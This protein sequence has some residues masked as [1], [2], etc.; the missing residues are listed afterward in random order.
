MSI[1]P[2]PQRIVLIK[3]GRF[4][5]AEVMLGRSTHLVGPNNIGKTSLI[6]TVQFLYVA[7]FSEMRFSRSWDESQ[8]YYFRED[9]S[10]I[11]FETATSDGR[12][13]TLGL[14]GRGQM[15]GFQIDRFAFEGPYQRE[16]FLTEAETVRSFAEVKARLAGER[17]FKLLEPADI[18]LAVVG[19][20]SASP[21]LNMGI[22]PLKRSDRYGDFV[23]L[24]KNLLRLS[25]LSQQDIKDTLLNVYRHDIQTTEIDLYG[26]YA[27]LLTKLAAERAKLQNLQEVA[28]RSLG[29]KAARSKRDRA[30]KDLPAMYTVLVA[31]KARAQTL[32]QESLAKQEKNSRRLKVEE[33]KDAARA[34]ELERENTKIVGD[35]TRVSDW[36]DKMGAEKK[37]LMEYLPAIADQEIVRLKREVDALI[38]K[39][40]TLGDLAALTKS[41]ESV[42]AE[43]SRK[44]VQRDKHALL[45]GTK[46]SHRMDA[47]ALS[48]LG[49][50]FNPEILRLPVEP[51]GIQLT[52]EDS[53]VETLENFHSSISGDSFAGAGVA[54]PLERLRSGGTLPVVDI[55]SLNDELASLENQAQLLADNLDAARNRQLIEDDRRAKKT[56][57]DIAEAMQVRY[58]QWKQDMSSLSGKKA[59]LRSLEAAK[60]ANLAARTTIKDAGEKRVATRYALANELSE[61]KN[62]QKQIDSI[63]PT[64]VDPTWPLGLEDPSWYHM[65]IAELYDTYSHTYSTLTDAD[66]EV[67]RLLNDAEVTYRDGFSGS[68]QDERIDSLLE[69]VDSLEQNTR[70]FRDQLGFVIQGMRASFNNMFKAYSELDDCVKEFSRSIG[71][72]SISNLSQMTLQLYENTEVTKHYRNIRQSD[73][74]DDPERTEEAIKA[75]S[76]TIENNRV[77]RLSDWFG[78]RFVITDASGETKRYDDLTVMESNGTTMAIKILVNIV[79]IRAMMR[80]NKPFMI[81]FYIDEATQIDESNLREIVTVANEMGFCPVLASTVPTSVAENIDSVRWVGNRVVIDPKRRITR[82]QK[83]ARAHPA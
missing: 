62:R 5:Y 68:T 56:A 77:L 55:A 40:A 7:A 53:L 58:R 3:A 22:V 23:Y 81:P 21:A 2:G 48:D 63:R 12:T 20:Y 66:A 10:T 69:A 35:L 78:V 16:D 25:S 57:L 71:K 49:R 14:R 37:E 74:L 38:V 8:R 19:D 15:G 60:A 33:E 17:Y 39:L 54:I 50:I 9:V 44:A 31:A 28:R 80:R 26:T 67:A 59:E 72:V 51:G 4:D 36:I 32:F 30:R 75:I 34:G 47:D 61:L 70:S 45:L 41:L 73:L 64:P 46:L 65:D 11:L 79:L 13:V 83:A 29:L 52:D 1:T 6:A 43:V 76:N 82:H 27:D 42:R 24:L 18:R